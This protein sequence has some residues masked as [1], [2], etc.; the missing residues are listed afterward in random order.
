MGESRRI[1]HACQENQALKD[2]CLRRF[3]P[4]VTHA[5]NAYSVEIHPWMREGDQDFFFGFSEARLYFSAIIPR[6]TFLG[7]LTNL[8]DGRQ[9]ALQPFPSQQVRFIW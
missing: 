3:R 1:P 5:R 7:S 4:H 6:E 9:K 2:F 8:L